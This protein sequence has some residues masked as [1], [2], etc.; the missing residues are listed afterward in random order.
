[1]ETPSLLHPQILKMLIK[2]SDES[3]QRNSIVPEQNTPHEDETKS[4][5][6]DKL[7]GQLTIA[8]QDKHK[9]YEQFMETKKFKWLAIP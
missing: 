4:K 7:M 8:R 5:R 3:I 1:M 6:S 2:T 9:K